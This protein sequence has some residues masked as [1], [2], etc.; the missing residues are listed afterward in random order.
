[1]A[2]T[3]TNISPVPLSHKAHR[4]L[5]VKADGRTEHLVNSHFARLGL[6]EF[7]DAGLDSP[8]IF[9]KSPRGDFI[10]A[11]M[12]GIEVGENLFLEDG[13]WTGGYLP[14][15]VRAYPFTAL[16]DPENVEKFYLGIFENCPW[17]NQPDGDLMIDENGE[18]TA[19]MEDIQSFLTQMHQQDVM[20][21]T[22]TRK[23]NDMGLLVE[24]NLRVQNPDTG[25]EKTTGGVFIVDLEKFQQLPDATILELHRDGSLALI[26][27][28]L[29]SL[30]ALSRLMMRK[31]LR[32]AVPDAVQ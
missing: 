1:M 13:K 23:L 3:P 27:A 12:W 32:K 17:L 6:V 15:I 21:T 10:A 30:K 11:S 26:H 24:Q 7:M 25:E 8:I 29:M 20:T 18:K 19:K 28:H 4:G 9:L 31:Q 2:D 14:A 16:P 22:F 5:R